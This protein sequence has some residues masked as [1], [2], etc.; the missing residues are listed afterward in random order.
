M[1]KHQVSAGLLNEDDLGSVAGKGPYHH[2]LLT[3][4]RSVTMNAPHTPNETFSMSHGRSVDVVS[5]SESH[6]S[7]FLRPAI[8][9]F[10]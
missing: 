1:E 4:C 3:V 5:H 8:L 2:V 10:K 9:I 7:L 6:I